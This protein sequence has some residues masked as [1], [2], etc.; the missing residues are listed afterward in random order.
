MIHEL[1]GLRVFIVFVDSLLMR[2]PLITHPCGSELMAQ[3]A[4]S[5]DPDHSRFLLALPIV[6]GFKRDGKASVPRFFMETVC[7]WF[8]SVELPK[9]L[10]S[11]SGT[12]KSAKSNP[13]CLV[14]GTFSIGWHWGFKCSEC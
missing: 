9:W 2:E 3:Q 14:E 6:G 7:L 12:Q 5:T 4:V 1:S 13:S 8:D 11:V 10:N